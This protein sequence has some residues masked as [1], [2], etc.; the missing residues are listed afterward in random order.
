MKVN[1]I[2]QIKFNGIKLSQPNFDDVKKLRLFLEV[3]GIDVVGYKNMYTK[4]GSAAD[5][6]EKIKF[7]RNHFMLFD[8]ECG[9][10]IFP[11]IKESWLIANPDFE[12]KLIE[13]VQEH[14]KKAML[15]M[16]I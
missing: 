11:W 15:N 3:S 10:I 2:S 14:D 7:A 4:S 8:N 16:F 12:R 5:I 9:F 13:I 1:T 6:Y